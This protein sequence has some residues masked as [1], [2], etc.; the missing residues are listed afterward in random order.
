MYYKFIAYINYCVY[1][2]KQLTTVLA[3]YGAG[4]QAVCIVCM[5]AD[6]ADVHMYVPGLTHSYTHCLL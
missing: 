2:L 6:Y 5:L 3:S 1:R 4:V